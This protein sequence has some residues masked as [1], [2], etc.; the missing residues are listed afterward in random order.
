MDDKHLLALIQVRQVNVYLAVEASGSEQGG[1]EHVGT[2]GGSQ[3]DDTRVGAEAVHLRQQGIQR[4]LPLVVAAHRRIPAAGTADGVDLVDEDD[5]GRLGL[6]LLEQVADTACSHTDEHLHE[7]GTRHREER[8]ASLSGHSLGQ[9]RLTRSRRPHEQC[10]LGDLAAQ[11]GIFLRILQKFYNLLYLL[12]GTGLSGHVLERD[13]Q[14]AAL[15]IHLGLRLADAEH[16]VAHAHAAAAHTAH[17]EYP[18]TDD[19]DKGQNVVEQHVEHLVLPPVLITEVAREGLVLLGLVDETLHLVHGANLHIHVRVGARLLCALVEHVA[20][21]LRLHIHPE[22]VL[23]LV[24][25]DLG[26]VAPVDHRLEFRVG[27][28]LA[29]AAVVGPAA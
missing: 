12:L 17:E 2:V 9:Q 7:V 28:M 8:H 6:S 11:V 4:V 13:A 21:M 15:L 5:A 18:G 24:D 26:G 3:D 10:A 27:S 20:D 19:D 22:R 29:H 23:I 25:Y 1:V 14:V 16:I